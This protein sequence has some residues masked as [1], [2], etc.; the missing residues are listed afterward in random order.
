MHVIDY[1]IMMSNRDPVLAS[2]LHEIEESGSDR[3]SLSSVRDDKSI[4][5][6][7]SFLPSKQ[8]HGDC[9]LSIYSQ[10]LKFRPAVRPDLRHPYLVDGLFICTYCYRE[11]E[12]MKTT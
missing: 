12:P 7:Y 10:E 5:S 3:S 4:F 9:F 2:W 6:S 11:D 8:S 1:K